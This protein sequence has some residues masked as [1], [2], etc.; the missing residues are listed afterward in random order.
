MV[1]HD[2]SVEEHTAAD[3]SDVAVADLFIADNS[4]G[5][6]QKYSVN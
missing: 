5:W 6:E 2:M 3:A 4:I 1:G